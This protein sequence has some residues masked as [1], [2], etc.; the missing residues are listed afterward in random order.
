MSS[1]PGPREHVSAT[2]NAPVFQKAADVCRGGENQGQTT[3]SGASFSN[4]KL[5]SNIG[6]K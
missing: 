4:E 3:C 1:C 6:Q 5:T 2:A